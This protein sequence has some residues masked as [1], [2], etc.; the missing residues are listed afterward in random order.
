MQPVRMLALTLAASFFVA[1]P[2]A[3]LS[4][5]EWVRSVYRDLLHRTPTSQEASTAV[6]ILQAFPNQQQLTRMGVALKLVRSTEWVDDLVGADPFKPGLMQ[7][8]VG[9]NT[10]PQ[11]AGYYRCR[12]Q[13]WGWSDERIIIDIISSTTDDTCGAFTRYGSQYQGYK[14]RAFTLNPNY[15]ACSQLCT[16]G[17]TLPVVLDQIYW[18]LLGRHATVDELNL[19]GPEQDQVQQTLNVI[20]LPAIFGLRAPQAQEYLERLVRSAF[21]RFLRRLPSEQPNTAPLSSYSEL[22]YF[23]G[24]VHSVTSDNEFFYAYLVSLPE[25]DTAVPQTPPAFDSVMGVSPNPDLIVSAPSLEMFGSPPPIIAQVVSPLFMNSIVTTSIAAVQSL[26]AQ[27]QQQDQTLAAQNLT[28]SAQEGTIAAQQQT[29]IALAVDAFG[30][31]ATK[32]AAEALIATAKAKLTEAEGLLCPAFLPCINHRVLRA[33][34]LLLL[35]QSALGSGHYEDAERH[36]R[37]VYRI[38]ALAILLNR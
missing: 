35:A 28:I 32:A 21:L 8:L 31:P 34:A 22:Q 10:G 14:N 20:L 12:V 1:H 2:S 9:T 29:I 30:G 17:P 5:S 25:Y 23:A 15:A 33:R 36:A 26:S 13:N 37:E 18:D 4:N 7:V 16:A 3:A 6:Q 11:G 38:A 24:I 27:T 19:T